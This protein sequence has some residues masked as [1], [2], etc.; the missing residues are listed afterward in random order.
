[1]IA[2]TPL[3]DHCAVPLSNEINRTVELNSGRLVQFYIEPGKN[4]L[5][6][7]LNQLVILSAK[8]LTRFFENCRKGSIESFL[9]A[10]PAFRLG[11]AARST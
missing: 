3:W 4:I 8:V 2:S 5:M 1:M 9:K 11:G 10:R 7:N 6:W